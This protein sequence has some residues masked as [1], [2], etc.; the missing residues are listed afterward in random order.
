MR[1]NGQIEVWDPTNGRRVPGGW[2]PLAARRGAR[3]TA[4]RRTMIVQCD[5]RRLR[6]FD[7]A[8]RRQVGSAI[9]LPGGPRQPTVLFNPGGTLFL[10][11]NPKQNLITQLWHVPG[12]LQPRLAEPTIRQIRYTHADLHPDGGSVVFGLDQGRP[13]LKTALAR[14]A[15]SFSAG[16]YSTVTG[17]PIGPPEI[18]I[19]S[20]PT[21]SPD[22]R[23][24]A[25]YSR[26]NLKGNARNLWPG[27]SLA[28]FEADTGQYAVPP[29][30][31][32]S[33]AHS[34]AFDPQGQFLALGLV[35][36]VA[37]YDVSAQRLSRKFLHPG[38]INPIQYSPD[39]D[40]LV[41]YSWGDWGRKPIIR[42]WDVSTG[43]LAMPDLPLHPPFPKQLD[44]SLRVTWQFR[45]DAQ[46]L[47]LVDTWKS[48]IYHVNIAMRS[49]EPPIT[50]A[51]PARSLLNS[52]PTAIASD[53]SR[54]AITIDANQVQ[55]F[56]T[57][58]GKPAGSVLDHPT[59]I[60]QVCYSRDGATLATTCLDGSV[61]LW[62]AKT[63][64]RLGPT[65]RHSAS[66][67]EIAFT[68]KSDQLQI[69]QSDANVTAWPVPPIQISQGEPISKPTAKLPDDGLLLDGSARDQTD[70]PSTN[71]AIDDPTEVLRRLGPSRKLDEVLYQ[72]H[73]HVA[74]DAESDGDLIAASW[75]LRRLIELRP[76]EP[77]LVF[78]LARI[79]SRNGRLDRAAALYDQ[80]ESEVDPDQM[81]AWFL[82]RSQGNFE[83]NQAELAL[84]YLD[85]I[86]ESPERR[87]WQ[88][89]INRARIL[90]LLNQDE[91]VI[92]QRDSALDAGAPNLYKLGLL[93]DH[94]RAGRID[95]ALEIAP[96]VQ[97]QG[98]SIYN[99]SLLTGLYAKGGQRD[100]AAQLAQS[101]FYTDMNVLGSIHLESWW[102]FAC[103]L[104][105]SGRVEEYQSFTVR[106]LE[107]FAVSNPM[108]A[109]TNKFN[110]ILDANL[111]G[112]IPPEQARIALSL[113]EGKYGR[114]RTAENPQADNL[115]LLGIALYR[116]G[117]FTEAIEVLRK[118]DEFKAGQEDF[119]VRVYLAMAYQALGQTEKARHFVGTIRPEDSPYL[120]DHLTYW[121]QIYSQILYQEAIR[122]IW[123]SEFPGNPFVPQA[124]A[125]PKL[126]NIKN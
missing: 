121:S 42:I 14:G 72:W 116:H 18:S 4:D 92:R 59:P 16:Q 28:I 20:D 60:A 25:I 113:A 107:S 111:M 12:P 77:S 71:Q 73:L 78:R 34:L 94:C 56:D 85:R 32:N 74:K 13:S 61:R 102:I 89:P 88:I 123:D 27:Q 70:S 79:E 9:P 109:E 124:E 35:N 40:Y 108:Q 93:I 8:S 57:K 114:L 39:G 101:S 19:V 1:D 80:L 37:L 47:V 65:R 6:Y 96:H 64:L 69:A 67:L 11:S 98:L 103:A 84:W 58:T 49:F 97:L 33:L 23:Y 53:G 38:P 115:T 110:V 63:H 51:S 2:R 90:D 99:R 52:H 31:T 86:E 30:Q 106:L 81:V 117:Q 82:M 95:Q 5:D 41:G 21:Y 54:V 62:D 105:A 26:V 68:P 24:Y 112:P 66:V 10:V 126:T 100:R 43:Q 45:R 76:D 29:F 104:L 122:F 119:L 118:C 50:L 125:S 55:V 7:L 22:G 36:G 91:Q 83:G 87:A 48:Q 15:F 3:L 46:K 44:H 17:L 75:H 120:K